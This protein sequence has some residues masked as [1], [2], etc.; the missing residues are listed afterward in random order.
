MRD[1]VPRLLDA[2]RRARVRA[3]FLLSFGPDNAGKAIWNVF[4]K[5]VFLKKMIR[6]GAPSLYGTRTMLSGTLLPAR[7]I[8]VQYP[9]LVRQI[10]AEGHEVGIHAWDHR[11]WQDHLHEMS[12]AA[13]GEEIQCSWDAFE[14]ILGRPARA[15]G[16]PAWYA[17]ATSLALQDERGL[18]Y[19]S[20]LRGGRLGFPTLGGYASTTLQVPTTQPCLEELLAAGETDLARCADLVLAEPPEGEARVLP[21]HAEVEGGVYAHFLETLLEGI[22]DSGAPV[23]TLEELARDRLAA[24]EP[25]P[26]IDACIREIPGRS[27]E[28]FAPVAA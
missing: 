25:P 13:I 9:D 6:S 2:F 8:A 20:D 22:R 10:E 24:A 14:A 17:T 15:M 4:T 12:R 16:A 26:R 19:A 3:T 21:L 23:I 5:R 1:G 28:V 27:G 7:M 11:L 18:V